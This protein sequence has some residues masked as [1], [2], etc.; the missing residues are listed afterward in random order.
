MP[1]GTGFKGSMYEAIR[2]LRNMT[3]RPRLIGVYA[4]TWHWSSNLGDLLSEGGRRT[5]S[6]HYRH[7]YDFKVNI[8]TSFN[9]ESVLQLL[10]RGP[11]HPGEGT[12]GLASLFRCLRPL[13]PCLPA[14]D[15]GR[16]CA[17]IRVEDC[18]SPG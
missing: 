6:T 17:I 8:S 15:S 7:I 2:K 9:P 12:S 16:C 18:L 4:E 1:V 11:L 14:A 13:L 3:T 5:D 10:P